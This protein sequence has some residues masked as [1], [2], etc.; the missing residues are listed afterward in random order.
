MGICTRKK[1][2]ER[3]FSASPLRGD[4][5]SDSYDRINVN[6]HSSF[7]AARFAPNPATQSQLKGW[8]MTPSCI[9]V[10]SQRTC[11]NECV[12]VRWRAKTSE[13]TDVAC[14]VVYALGIFSYT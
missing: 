11:E 8:V 7:Q 1:N 4:G 12:V 6:T 5:G 14:D 13:G 2:E 3:T 9:L 10:E